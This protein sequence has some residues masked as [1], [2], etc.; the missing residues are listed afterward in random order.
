VFAFHETNGIFLVQPNVITVSFTPGFSV[1]H[2]RSPPAV[3][4][5]SPSA[6]LRH[7]VLL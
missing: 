7:L 5:P 6:S 3:A 4:K 1:F 2:P